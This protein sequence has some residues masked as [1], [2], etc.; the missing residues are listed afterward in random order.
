MGLISEFE[1]QQKRVEHSG[2]D[3]VPLLDFERAS[4]RSVVGRSFGRSVGRTE[5]DTSGE[6]VFW[7][8]TSFVFL[9]IGVST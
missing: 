6:N 5:G 9:F 4:V 2:N 1:E 3:F 7:E 8:M